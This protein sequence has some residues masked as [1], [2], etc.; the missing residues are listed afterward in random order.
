MSGEL[1]LGIDAGQTVAKAVLARPDGRQV[2][3]AAAATR[4]SSPRPRWQERDMDELWAQVAAAVRDCLT[5]AGVDG[6]A[7]ASVGVCGHNDGLHLVDA[8]LRPVRPAVLATDSRAIAEAAQFGHGE[9]AR[10]ALALTGQLPF[11]GSPAMVLRWL[12]AAE[13]ER[14]G[15]I[16]WVLFCKDWIRLQLTGEVATDPTEASA[17]FTDVHSQGY[18]ADVLDLLDL[19]EL[20]PALPPLLGCW[21]VAG[22]VTAAAAEATGLAAGTPVVTGAHD[23]DAAALGLGAVRTGAT[24]AVLGTFCINQVVG[25]AP[26]LDPRWQARAFLRP[27]RWLHMSTSPA[28]AVNLDWAVR[29]FGP[30]RP[31]GSPDPAAAVEQAGLDRPF[32]ADAPLWLPFLHGSP[33]GDGVPATLYGLRGWHE[34]ADVLRAVL[35][36]VVLN[37]RTHLGALAERF[38]AA[39]ALRVGGGG[40][41]SP[42]WTQLLADAVRRPV[43]VTDASEAGAR[44]AALLAGLGVGTFESLDAAAEQA[45]RVVRRHE[46]ADSRAAALDERYARWLDLVAAL[47]PLGSSL[48]K[49]PGP[50]DGGAA[51]T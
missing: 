34:R 29:R 12:R 24:S 38:P 11:P 20:R 1:L 31:D 51:T 47:E 19:A 42:A 15:A 5:S 41:R 28:G 7:V 16:A 21:E 35:E 9:R 3:A 25:D 48:G 36:G 37:H 30:W 23:V 22:E 14:F 43:E 17:S 45:V 6:A 40:A 2:A 39:G 33:H 46:P 27:G 32:A 8:A 26:Q 13:P 18:S 50:P 44:G 10:Q 49:S 4:T